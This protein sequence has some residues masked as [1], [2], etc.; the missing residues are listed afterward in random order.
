MEGGRPRAV[1][2]RL[3][4]VGDKG[5]ACT[6]AYPPQISTRSLQILTRSAQILARRAQILMKTV[7]N[8]MRTVQIFTSAPGGLR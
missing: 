4:G 2:E 3:E 5:V 6:R 7:Q 8:L 1:E